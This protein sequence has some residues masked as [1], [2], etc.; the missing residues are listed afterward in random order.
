MI[1]QLTDDLLSDVTYAQQPSLTYEMHI[2]EE[3]VLGNCDK[4]PAMEQAI[5]KILNTERYKTPIYSWNY[6]VELADLF[7]K[8]TTFC[9]PEIERRIKEALMQDDRIKDV[10]DF[11]FSVPKRR[12]VYV[13]FKVDTTEGT[14]TAEKEVN[15]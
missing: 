11:V 3:K 10:Y 15:I 13:K 8:P 1:P 12:V 9:I 14:V 2:N 6:G 5:F 7:G 4:I